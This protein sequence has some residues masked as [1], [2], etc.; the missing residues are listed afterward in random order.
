MTNTSIKEIIAA[1]ESEWVEFKSHFELN[2]IGQSICA[3][4]NARGG[5]LICGVSE[6]REIIGTQVD[7]KELERIRQKLLDKISPK[8]AWSTNI[9]HVDGKQV[10]VVDVP[11]GLD[12][13]YIYNDRIFIRQN[14]ET[15]AASGVDITALINQRHTEGTR[16]ERFPALGIRIEDLDSDEILRTANE[17]IQRGRYHFDKSADVMRILEQLNLM[18]S[19]GMFLNSAVALF[20]K[21]PARQFPQMRVRVAHF[22]KGSLREFDDIRVFEGNTF[23]LIE[24]IENFLKMNIAI[25]SE[26]PKKGLKRKDMPSYPW[27]ALREAML[28]AIVHRDYAAFDG[29]MS[30][31]IHDDRIEFW[32]SGSLPSGITV[33]SLKGSHTSRPHNPDIAHVFFLRGLIEQWG[34]GTKEIVRYCREISLPEPEWSTDSGGIR[35]IIRLREPI[36]K[37]NVF[38]LNSRQVNLLKRVKSDEHIS[39]S[40]YFKEVANKVKERRARTDLIQLTK[41]G[42]LRRQGH[43]PSTVY[44]RTTKPVL[45]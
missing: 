26:L 31:A 3:F 23:V 41:A 7:S 22:K 18:S 44:I 17:A 13:P 28:N 14:A 20:G 35:L 32:N 1:G 11:Q 38:E 12:K 25:K 24:K 33:E 30:V 21:S 8:A 19:D 15:I 34:I 6:N 2:S 36:N 39:P 29:G 42:Y 5:T 37:Q 43:G 45:D 27:L 16:W 10:F 40:E 9:V 4:L